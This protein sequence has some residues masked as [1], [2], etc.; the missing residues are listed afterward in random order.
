M[1]EKLVAALLGVGGVVLGVIATSIGAA[2]S[3]RQRIREVELT[4]RQKLRENY[5]ANARAYLNH[6]YVPLSTLLTRLS[7]AYLAFRPYFG[8]TN[9][10]P[11]HADEF[12][13]ACIEF[14]NRLA[15][16]IGAGADAFLTT[17]L[18]E[19]LDSFRSLLNSSRDATQVR[20]KVVFGST[21][22]GYYSGEIE[23]GKQKGGFSWTR[24]GTAALDSIGTAT[25][26][27]FPLLPF[28]P[29]TQLRFRQELLSAPITS[30]EFEKRFMADVRVLRSLVKEVTLGSQS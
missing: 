18:E 6:V 21:L 22:G 13:A 2:Y 7:A 5:L 25:V 30:P 29:L 20:K 15:E 26:S 11:K 23:S 17:E 3:A 19:R 28:S 27:I 14:D 12:R 8:G 10:D 16:L 4:Y 1:D 24:V 9:S